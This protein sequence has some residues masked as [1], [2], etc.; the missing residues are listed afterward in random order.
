MIPK[1]LGKN[2]FSHKKVFKGLIGYKF[3]GALEISGFDSLNYKHNKSVRWF[4]KVLE[5]GGKEGKVVSYDLWRGFGC[6]LLCNVLMYT[7]FEQR[8]IQEIVTTDKSQICHYTTLH[9][10]NMSSWKKDFGLHNVTLYDCVLGPSRGGETS[11]RAMKSF[12]MLN[13]EFSTFR[14]VMQV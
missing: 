7:P 14:R 3:G 5:P 1:V 8:S 10:T 12:R 6:F 4:S 9:Y 2:V 13:S 11:W